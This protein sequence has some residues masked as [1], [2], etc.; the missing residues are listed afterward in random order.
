[1]AEKLI[2]NSN[3]KTCFLLVELFYSATQPLSVE[4][5]RIKSTAAAR[6]GGTAEEEAVGSILHGPWVFVII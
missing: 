1:M 6:Q 2:L 3:F 4:E 5:W